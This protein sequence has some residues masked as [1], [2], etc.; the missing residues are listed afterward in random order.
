MEELCGHTSEVMKGTVGLPDGRGVGARIAV[1]DF[2]ITGQEVN[3]S[4][5]EVKLWADCG[6]LR[7]AELGRCK[8]CRQSQA[9]R[10]MAAGEAGGQHEPRAETGQ[11]AQ[12][13]DEGSLVYKGPSPLEEVL[14]SRRFIFF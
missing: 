3:P 5:A 11:R 7:G 4:E 12:L 9:A 1:D 2:Q 14:A 10:R 13:H 8:R 6:M